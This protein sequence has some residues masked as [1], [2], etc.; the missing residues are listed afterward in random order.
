[1]KVLVNLLDWDT[2]RD[3]VVKTLH[4]GYVLCKQYGF[5]PH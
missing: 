1:M 2:Q 4:V 3:H 5:R